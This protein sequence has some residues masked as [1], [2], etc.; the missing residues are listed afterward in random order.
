MSVFASDITVELDGRQVPAF[1]VDNRMAI[2]F[3][4]LKEYGDYGYDNTNRASVLKLSE[5]I[6]VRETAPVVPVVPTLPIQPLLPEESQG[7]EIPS[8]TLPNDDLLMDIYPGF[9]MKDEDGREIFIV[10]LDTGK[11]HVRSCRYW[12]E[13]EYDW[14][15][16]LTVYPDELIASDPFYSYCLVCC[17]GRVH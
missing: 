2:Y 6:P 16:A 5:K 3:T 4:E 11:I 14:P 7:D 13:D 15:A 12:R 9:P 1:N 8:R 17:K 10:N